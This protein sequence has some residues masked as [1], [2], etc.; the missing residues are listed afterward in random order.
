M[1]VQFVALTILLAVSVYQII[2]S[3][4]LPSSSDSV[5][6]V[7]QWI[8]L[9]KKLEIIWQHVDVMSYFQGT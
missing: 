2:V 5:P 9:F 3:D 6:V 1:Y 8:S 4:K 7:G